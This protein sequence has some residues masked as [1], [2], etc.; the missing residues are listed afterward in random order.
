MVDCVRW[1]KRERERQREREIENK[2]KRES[3]ISRQ[4]LTVGYRSRVR[5]SKCLGQKTSFA[6]HKNINLAFRRHESEDGCEG[7]NFVPRLALFSE[8]LVAA[9]FHI[10]TKK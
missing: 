7:L 2:R 10:K 8:P 6:Q 4:P 9:S 1:K 5:P 3:W